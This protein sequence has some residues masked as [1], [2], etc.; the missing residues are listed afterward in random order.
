MKKVLFLIVLT[1]MFLVVSC[2][3][4]RKTENPDA[5]ETVTDE[6]S[7][8]AEE[9]GDND[10]SDTEVSDTTSD[11]SDSTDDSADSST[12]DTDSA[13]D[14]TTPDDD[15]ATSEQDRKQGELYGECYPNNTCNEGLI[16][17]IENNICI[18][19]PN[20]QNDDDTDTMDDSGDSIADNDTDTTDTADTA[21]TTDTTDTDTADTVDTTDT[22]DTTDSGNDSGDSTTDNDTDTD[23]GDSTSD[24][25]ADG[26]TED[27]PECGSTTSGTPCKDP[28]KGWIWSEK[29]SEAM[30]WEEAVR[31][32]DNMNEGD[33]EDWHLPN[34]SELRTLIKDCPATEVGGACS[35]TANCLSD[36][37]WSENSCLS[38]TSDINHSKLGDTGWFWSASARAEDNETAWG[39]YFS[40][41]KLQNGIPLQ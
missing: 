37:C 13:T 15:S 25:D 40:N 31:H 10:P 9:T 12:D 14:T 3:G 28:I 7:A 19:D 5:D 16:C 29:S 26:S 24:E 2:G 32:C 38:C 33:S 20:A 34:I 23:S 39:I 27:I 35:V 1:A 22:T 36:G 4:D 18:K 21:D 6:D 41:A 8:D 30:T 17:D 11:T